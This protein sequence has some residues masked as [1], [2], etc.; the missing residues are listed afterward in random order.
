MLVYLISWPEQRSSFLFNPHVKRVGFCVRC[1]PAI[2]TGGG[3][4]GRHRS[5]SQCEPP[6]FS[7]GVPSHFCLRHMT[8]TTITIKHLTHK[9][10]P[11]HAVTLFLFN[12]YTTAGSS[13][14]WP[15]RHVDSEKLA[16]CVHPFPLCVKA[17]LL[18]KR[19]HCVHEAE[20]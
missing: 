11:A 3:E 2:T 20:G 19:L 16:C 8:L 1:D 7:R 15:K 4:P 17:A 12:H 10:C 5:P 13:M 6:L 9:W 18:Y 14:S